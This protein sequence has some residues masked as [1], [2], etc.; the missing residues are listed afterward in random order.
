MGK[1][2]ILPTHIAN[3]IAAGEVVE[4]PA[5][6][7]K[8]LLENAIDADATQITISIEQGGTKKIQVVDNGCGMDKEDLQKCISRH[9]TSKVKSEEDLEKIKS[10][11]FRGEALSSIAAVSKI[12]IKSKLSEETSGHQL[13]SEG[14][15]IKSIEP[16]GIPPGT[17]V[18]VKDLFYNV[19]ARKK[20]LKTPRT[21]FRHISEIVTDN[22]LSFTDIAFKLVHNG[23]EIFNL[24]K[25]ASSDSSNLRN[26]E[27]RI[28]ELLGGSLSDN[29]LPLFF[30]HHHL[31]IEGFV[32]KPQA[33]TERAQHQYIFV[34]Q[35]RVHDKT[36]LGAVRKAYGT[37]LPTKSYPPF[38]IF[39]KMPYDFVDVNV[40]P[41]KE[42]VKFAQPDFIFRSVKEAVAKALAKNDLTYQK[43][44]GAFR[45][46]QFSPKTPPARGVP[47]LD[48]EAEEPQRYLKRVLPWETGELDSPSREADILQIHNL[49]LI[50]ETAGGIAILDQHAAHERILYEQLLEDFKEEKAQRSVQPLLVAETIELAPPDAEILKDNLEVFD[51]TGFEITL[52]GKNSFKVDA[53]PT[54]LKDRHAASLI[55]EIIADLKDNRAPRDVDQKDLRTISFLACRSAVKA[56]DSLTPEERRA[57]VNNLEQTKTKYTCPHGRPAKVEISLKE[58]KKMFKRH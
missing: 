8:E 56:G 13:T 54:I 3:K 51:K 40:H 18:T 12:R 29:L 4:R 9:A 24:A 34:N 44:D 21:E 28:K 49:Y 19:P 10:M 39:L 2:E 30:D 23:R 50:K 35:R 31:K 1:I 48:S 37:L 55:S 33:A 22:A 42:E 5:S 45:R 16:I 53:V 43:T 47:E 6:A 52:F 15:K 32:T 25:S 46:Q 11:G 7:V 58:L 27:L 14:G 41:R 17:S 38:L 26:R 57:I 20:F 36:V